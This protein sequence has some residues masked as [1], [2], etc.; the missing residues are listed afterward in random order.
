[1]VSRVMADADMETG[2]LEFM[3]PADYKGTTFSGEPFN[4]NGGVL[5]AATP[6]DVSPTICSINNDNGTLTAWEAVNND[7]QI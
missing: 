2:Q 6:D 4:G 1:M 5:K 3:Y 7:K